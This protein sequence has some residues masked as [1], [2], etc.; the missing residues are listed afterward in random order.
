M[1]IDF[2][3]LTSKTI[4]IVAILMNENGPQFLSLNRSNNLTA[5]IQT[6]ALDVSKIDDLTNTIDPQFTSIFVNGLYEDDSKISLR[7]IIGT[8][9]ANSYIIDY[10]FD[11]N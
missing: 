5:I 7:I 1:D 9:N 10:T 6:P 11:E 8:S 2:V 3:S 4:D